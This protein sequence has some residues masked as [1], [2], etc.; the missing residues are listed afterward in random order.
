[1]K[2]S[3]PVNAPEEVE[4]L[5][6]A[7]ADELYCG[8]LDAWWAERYGDHDSA[9]RR[10]GRANLSTPAELEATVREARR[11]GLPIHLAL[12]A[13]YTEPQL[14]HLVELCGRFDDWG[15]AGVI[16]SDLGLL[17]RL[18]N[19]WYSRDCDLAITLSL[20]A[21]AQNTATLR[22]YRQLD[23][24]RVVLPRFV[25]WQEAGSLLSGVPGMEASVMA[26][27]D[28]CPLVDGYC[29]HRHGVS[30]PDRAPAGGACAPAS[31]ARN[32][33][34]TRGKEDAAPFD[35]GVDAPPLYTFD[36]TYRTH[37]CLGSSCTYLEPYPCAA[38]YLRYFE[39]AGVG[40][41][42]I[43]G[44]GRAL[45]ERLRALRFLREA[46]AME[47]D[48][49]RRALYR[50]TFRQPCACYYGDTTQSRYAIEPITAHRPVVTQDE[51]ERGNVRLGALPGVRVVNVAWNG[52]AEKRIRVGS[53]TNVDEFLAALKSLCRGVVPVTE[54]ATDGRGERVPSGDAG[55]EDV[56]GEGDAYGTDDPPSG[57]DAR[58]S[59]DSPDG[60]DGCGTSDPSGA[61]DAAGPD[62]NLT[63]LV[64]PLSNGTLH[65][66]ITLVPT[67]IN[68]VPYGT[69]VAVNDLGTLSELTRSLAPYARM[70]PF[71]AEAGGALVECPLRLTLGTLLARS[72]DP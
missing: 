49:E 44:R 14:D 67:L 52:S 13:R 60:R 50:E 4:A 63:L 48:A 72:D 27:F 51:L 39:R 11:C 69:H 59:S 16:L 10:Q 6:A 19:E 30:H 25:G 70:L 35:A 56:Y 65:A 21:V 38:C 3:V 33:A 31:K 43:G 58:G 55:V 36:T 22:A 12:N 66:F 24:T 34:G 28:K 71:D 62:A 5:A 53:E 15:G 41:A 9:S 57:R 46:E 45:E 26:F 2:Y 32:L 68:H 1:M 54:N 40:T 64:P 8:Y 20:L 17:W 47:T 61:G 42:K 7:G 37:A 29:R 23:V 18:N